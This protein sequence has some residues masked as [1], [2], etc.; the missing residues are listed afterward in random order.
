ML[1][2]LAAG[3][4]HQPLGMHQ[5]QLPGSELPTCRQGSQKMPAAPTQLMG[6]KAWAQRKHQLGQAAGHTETYC[7]RVPDTSSFS[8]NEQVMPGAWGTMEAGV[9][10]QA[11]SISARCQALQRCRQRGM[12]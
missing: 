6:S 12:R 7:V 3:Q 11:A 1:H 10:T 9:C 4:D 8:S 2:W 5:M